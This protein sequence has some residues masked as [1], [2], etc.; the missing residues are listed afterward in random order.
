MKKFNNKGFTLV[1]ML[2]VIVI[3]IAIMAVAIPTISGSLK[4]NK[5]NQN[6]RYKRLIE[7]AASMYVTDNK[8]LVFSNVINNNL[9]Y[10]DVT[11]I[12]DNNYLDDAI[13]KDTNGNL[14]LDYV[15]FNRDEYSFSY[16]DSNNELVNC[17]QHHVG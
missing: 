7:E 16:S 3:L 11:D 4:K 12:R 15:I 1:E 14:L 5:F 6:E 2:A 9:C 8:E 10:I 17:M 13:F